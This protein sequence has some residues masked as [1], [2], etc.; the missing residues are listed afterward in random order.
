MAIIGIDASRANVEQRTGTEWYIY[1]LLR[2]LTTIIPAEHKVVLYTKEPLRS[3]F[4]VFPSQ[5]TN[6]VLRWPPQL[7]WTQLRLSLKMLRKRSR[8]D[9]LFIPAHTIP[10]IHPRKTVYVAHD[11]GFE[12]FSELYSRSYIGGSIMNALVRIGT[13]GVYG[14]SELDYHRWSM[15]FAIR[16]ATKVIAIS[17][18]TKSEL[19]EVYKVPSNQIS[20][21]YNGFSSQDYKPVTT[22]PSVP[23]YILFVGRLEYK[24]NIPNLI[25]AFAILKQK[26]HLPHQ[27]TLIGTPGFG[28]SEIQK[29]IIWHGLD[30]DVLMPG[31]VAQS[32]M[33]TL[34]SGAAAF[35]FPSHYEGFGI[36]ILE[37]LAC[38]ALVVCSD[39]PV[40]REIGQNAC[41]YFDKDDSRS[42]ARV[43]AETL[44]LSEAEKL[45]MHQAGQQRVTDFSWRACAQNTWQV[46]QSVLQLS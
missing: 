8:P 4:G 24:K 33:P 38:N 2:E 3:D 46:L 35:V 37:A 7:L 15:Q 23:P 9:I 20:V 31:Y 18:F 5:W 30:K 40:L 27:L 41:R 14:T 28:F 26:Y 29:R 10:M 39:I 25:D 17:K 32:H 13:L 43:I 16:H 21:V 34:M 45:Q 42:I 12:R 44:Q 36:P 6:Q 11:L 22:P 19:Q 1:S